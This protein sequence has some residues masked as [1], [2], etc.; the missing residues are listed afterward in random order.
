MALEDHGTHVRGTQAEIDAYRSQQADSQ[1]ASVIGGA[2][3]F[4]G[5]AVVVGIAA[6]FISANAAVKDAARASAAQ[7]NT[8]HDMYSKL[9]GKEKADKLLKKARG[10]MRF[11]TIKTVIIG[12][13]APFITL[14]L[15]LLGP[16][17][18]VGI[19]LFLA[20]QNLNQAHHL[21]ASL[22]LNPALGSLAEI[23]NE[24]RQGGLYEMF[25]EITV[26]SSNIFWIMLIIGSAICLPFYIRAAKNKYDIT[27]LTKYNNL[28]Y[29][30]Y[31]K[32]KCPQCKKKTRIL[33]LGQCRNC[34]KF[35]HNPS[36]EDAKALSEYKMNVKYD[37]YKTANNEFFSA[38][39]G[40]T[41]QYTLGT[42]ILLLLHFTLAIAVFM[43]TIYVGTLFL[44]P[45]H[46]D[47]TTI[48]LYAAGLVIG[49]LFLLLGTQKLL[50]AISSGIVKRDVRKFMKAV[51]AELQK[52]NVSID[53]WQ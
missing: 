36:Y 23:W 37:V 48:H 22:N 9:W 44:I 46:I 21:L 47:G 25:Q 34:F 42:W 26:L 27:L 6:L 45:M 53:N 1:A 38:E 3:A 20:A 31:P 28:L 5:I 50:G 41:V 39:I 7:I 8:W 35:M 15:M 16:V 32:T 11:Q 2:V 29:Q 24:L 49:A 19:P 51:R 43:G 18:L 17:I 4:A 14:T 30:N 10:K 13:L 52:H 12:M 40:R 33:S